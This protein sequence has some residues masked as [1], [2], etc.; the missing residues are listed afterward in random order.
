MLRMDEFAPPPPGSGE[1]ERL[2]TEFKNAFSEEFLN[3]LDTLDELGP[4]LEAELAG[5]WKVLA[6]EGGGGSQPEEGRGDPVEG[7]AG[8]GGGSSAGN[9]GLRSRDPP[10]SRRWR[11]T[12]M[13]SRT[14][15]SR[16][17]SISARARPGPSAAV[18]T[19][20]PQGSTIIA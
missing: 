10:Y 1:R 16:S 18:A 15:A 2:M 19:G 14:F 7:V 3:L 6:T 12:G 13:A 9:L 4:S 5:P 11:A 8:R 17:R 20:M